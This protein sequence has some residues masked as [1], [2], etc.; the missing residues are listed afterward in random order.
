MFKDLHE[1]PPSYYCFPYEYIDAEVN[2]KLDK[3]KGRLGGDE[4]EEETKRYVLSLNHD[5]NWLKTI[6]I[7][8]D[9]LLINREYINFFIIIYMR[10]RK[11][12][13]SYSSSQTLILLRLP[14][15][16]KLALSQFQLYIEAQTMNQ[17]FV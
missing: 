7:E 10:C 4:V 6:T 1:F 12:D 17:Y 5:P 16:E 15:F 13:S 11:D 2:N 9:K 14:R 3:I 8:I